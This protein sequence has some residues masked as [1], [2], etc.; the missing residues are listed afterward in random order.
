MWDSAT[1]PYKLYVYLCLSRRYKKG[2]FLMHVIKNLA[3][4][5]N[6]AN[7]QKHKSYTTLYQINLRKMNFCRL[8]LLD[9]M[10]KQI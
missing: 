6:L 5:I 2:N 8:V 3:L 10:K 4:L 7:R 9:I 1:I